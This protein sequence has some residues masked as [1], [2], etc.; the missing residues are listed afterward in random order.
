VLR[1]RRLKAGRKAEGDHGAIV[2]QGT[3]AELRAQTGTESLE[4]A[5][6]RLTGTTIRDETA[7]STDQMR[8]FAQMWRRPR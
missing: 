4:E 5:F 2:A 6:L 7:T 1:R 8:Q 3:S